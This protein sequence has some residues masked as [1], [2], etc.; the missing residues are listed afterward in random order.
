MVARDAQTN[1]AV[2]FEA[3]RWCEEAEG[4]RAEWVGGGQDDAPVVE[5]FSV[6]GVGWSAQGEVP[7]EE[8]CFEGRGGVVGGWSGG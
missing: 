8:V 5:A 6:G 2:G 3:A 1:L 7:F 4:G